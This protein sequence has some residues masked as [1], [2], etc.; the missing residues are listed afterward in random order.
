LKAGHPVLQ[1][2]FADLHDGSPVMATI[3]FVLDET[4]EL[5]QQTTVVSDGA[6]RLIY[7]G[8]QGRIRDYLRSHREWF[9]ANDN[10]GLIR[11]LVQLEVD[12]NS[13]IVGGPVDLLALDAKGA[14]WLQ[15]K[16]ECAD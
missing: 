1:A 2:I 15:K 10:A 4:G 3:G 13:G 5:R 8:Q 6:P 9:S 11:N 14:R 12:V 16:P 7:A